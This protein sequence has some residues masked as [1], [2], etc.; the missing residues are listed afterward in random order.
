MSPSMSPSMRT[1]RFA[2]VILF[3]A[4]AL[5]SVA[6]ATNN[7]IPYVNARLVPDSASPGGAG[8][9]L[10]VNGTGFVSGATVRWNGSART[11]TFVNGSQLTA[12]ISSADIAAAGTAFVTVL[13]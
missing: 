3:L 9:T 13:N 2:L 5:S 10:T 4:S 7:P 1:S 12:T 11:T 8:F 6:A